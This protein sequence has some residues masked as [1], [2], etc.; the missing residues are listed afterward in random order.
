MK[1][2]LWELVKVNLLPAG[3]DF[4]SCA[5]FTFIVPSLMSSDLQSDT[6]GCVLA[7][8]P[9]LAMIVGPRVGAWSDNCQSR[10]G[11]R[12]PFIFCISLIILLA[13]LMIPY[14]S[15]ISQVLPEKY[16]G[17]FHL[18]VLF[19]GIV[20]LDSCVSLCYTPFEAL[21]DDL[22][23][24]KGFV[25]R[26]FGIKSLMVSAGG[27]L[28]YLFCSLDLKNFWLSTF[29]GGAD[30][31]LFLT[32]FSVYA[33]LVMISMASIRASTF[34]DNEGNPQGL[35]SISALSTMILRAPLVILKIPAA[36]RML[37]CSIAEMIRS[38]F[39]MPN[40][41]HRLWFAHFCGWMGLMNLITYYT[42]YVAEVIFEGDPSA[43]VGSEPRNLYEE[44]I[45]Y[46]SI[47][48]FLQNI[49]AIV[50]AFYAED[51]IKFMGRRNAFVYSCVSFSL[52]SAAIFVCRS[53][54]VVIGATSLTGFLLAALQVLPYSLLSQYH[55]EAKTNAV[56][57]E[58]IYERGLCEMYALL[59]SA[60]YLSH[61]IP[62]AIVTTLLTITKSPLSYAACS[63]IFGCLGVIA[64]TQVHYDRIDYIRYLS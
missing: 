61:M 32:L 64:S 19:S 57:E 12:T 17:L 4:V 37:F 40:M 31:L 18:G 23:E 51:I 38:L 43:E 1:L 29:L 50:C 2:T 62:I 14:S 45:R 11:K 39:M 34:T 9:L 13:L 60:Y 56:G 16:S 5:A 27:A 6:V 15:V 20:M 3:L 53:V 44:G 54:P 7:C 26:A 52:A 25:Q 59:D 10:H 21:L 49:V 33:L 8:G 41:F 28:A 58:S 22:Y 47:G 46:G 48:L 30:K 24:S 42:E 63:A 55:K 36:I 35:I